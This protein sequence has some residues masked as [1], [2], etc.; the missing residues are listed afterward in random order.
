[1]K[2]GLWKGTLKMDATTPDVHRAP[3]NSCLAETINLQPHCCINERML[4]VQTK[5]ELV[6]KKSKLGL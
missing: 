4:D 5:S 3:V 2:L 6:G 1:M